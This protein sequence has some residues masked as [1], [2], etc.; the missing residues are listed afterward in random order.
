[1]I[2][3]WY[4]KK[5]VMAVSE[6]CKRK[7]VDYVKFLNTFYEG[8]VLELAFLLSCRGDHLQFFKDQIR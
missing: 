4:L 7:T 6:V 2:I 1:M 5:V 3:N 8:Y